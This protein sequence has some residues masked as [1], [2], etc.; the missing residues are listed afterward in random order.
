MLF[1]TTQLPYPPY[2]GGLIK[3]WRLLRFLAREYD[4]SLVTL[5]KGEDPQQV[6]ALQEAVALKSFY[7]EALNVERNASSLLR[8]YVAGKTLNMVRNYSPKVQ[9]EVSAQA[10]Q[11][12]CI[13]VDHYEMFQYVPEGYQGKVILHTHNAEFMMWKRFAE[14]ER[15][16]F[17]RVAL[18][19]ESARIA[20][21]EKE[22]IHRSDLVFA[23]P[24]DQEAFATL[25]VDQSKFRTTYH[26]GV[27]EMLKKPAL[28]FAQTKKALMF[29]GTLG[30]EANLDG[31]LWFIE[32]VW[33]QLEA[34]HDDLK[35]YIIGKRPPVRLREAAAKHRRII[36]TGFVE[37]PEEYY[38]SC[39]VLVV[40]L[41]FGSGIKVKILDGMYRG[42]PCVTTA[43]G[44]EGLQVTHG[45]EMSV[46]SG[47]QAF[48]T[49]TSRLLSDEAAWTQ[50]STAARK[51]AA[52]RYTWSDLLKAHQA[53]LQ[54]L[55]EPIPST[56]LTR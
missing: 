13:L 26:L 37:D 36:L 47:A 27:D 5:L 4:L 41:R 43:I 14:L 23:A 42:I 21:A 7:G 17:R 46:V 22:C 44:T 24:N 55:F 56:T 2:S 3:S 1:L 30:W 25:G 10:L 15:S 8:S 35:F 50:M 33:P 48:A 6:A 28:S 45:R 32:K 9:E 39:R 20:K 49:E 18:Q 16:P 29:M 19:K 31:L 52:E 12:D 40:P 53:D 38:T 54:E 51:R 34:K 11:H